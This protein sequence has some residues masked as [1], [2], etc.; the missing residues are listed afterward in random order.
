M[1]YGI[2]CPDA[3][4]NGVGPGVGRQKDSPPPPI[5]ALPPPPPPATQA[6]MF[7]MIDNYS[8]TDLG[9]CAVKGHHLTLI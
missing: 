7:A 3:G 5:R 1:C 6:T 4:V 8:L 9:T 2:N